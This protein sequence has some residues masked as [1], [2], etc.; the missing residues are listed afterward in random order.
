MKSI[1]YLK[2]FTVIILINFLNI[3]NSYGQCPPLPSG[4]QDSG[5]D[6][7]SGT[8]W[9]VEIITP[10]DPNEIIGPEGFDSLHWVSIKDHMGYTINYEND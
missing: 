10:S 2:Y 9:Q 3:S 4:S 7:D 1:T 8:N 5:L 6:D